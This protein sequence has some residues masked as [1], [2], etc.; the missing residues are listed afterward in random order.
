MRRA[1]IDR[2]NAKYLGAAP[3]F[4]GAPLVGT[5]TFHTP[6][7][8]GAP[9]VI[10]APIVHHGGLRR[11]IINPPVYEIVEHQPVVEAVTT[12]G[13][14]YEIVTPVVE[15][16]PPQP[17]RQRR[18]GCPWWCWLLLGLLLLAILLSAL[19]YLFRHELGL[20]PAGEE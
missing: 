14:V 16:T 15:V 5:S 7:V 18:A 4:V 6:H 20:V 1:S 8:V 13:R 3:T 9:T 10:G 17:V 19:G 11:S 2:V 12:P